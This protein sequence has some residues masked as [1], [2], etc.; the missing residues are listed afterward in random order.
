M[1]KTGSEIPIVDL[2]T[3]TRE[4]TRTPPVE[5]YQISGHERSRVI[6]GI[7]PSPGDRYREFI[8]PL[9]SGGTYSE[10]SPSSQ[11]RPTVA[12]PC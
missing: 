8:P 2:A 12:S 3:R 7:D 10:S 4:R 9:E 5:Q 1:W 6:D 11:T